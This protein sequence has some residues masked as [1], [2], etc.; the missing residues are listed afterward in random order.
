MKLLI[1]FLTL[2]ISSGTVAE[3]G[4]QFQATPVPSALQIVNGATYNYGDSVPA[5]EAFRHVANDHG[6]TYELI[7]LWSIF[8]DDVLRGESGYCPN[9]FRGATLASAQGCIIQT[10]GRYEDAGFGQ[11][12]G[13]HYNPGMWLCEEHGICSRHAVIRDPWTSMES[14]VWLVEREGSQPWCFSD[15]ARRYHKCWAAPDR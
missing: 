10:Q 14:L 12:I 5:M 7:E 15:W 6:W 3:R 4:E 11:L 2:V 8:I 1:L 13:V 9:L